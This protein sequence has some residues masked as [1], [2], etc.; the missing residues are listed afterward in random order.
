MYDH[1]HTRS[2][3]RELAKIIGLAVF[4][5]LALWAVLR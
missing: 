2:A 1:L 3:Y 4:A 5:A